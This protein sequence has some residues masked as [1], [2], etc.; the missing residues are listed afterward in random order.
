MDLLA[1]LRAK[2]FELRTEGERLIVSPASKLYEEDR[3]AIRLH[4]PALLLLLSGRGP[5]G[6]RL[7]FQPDPERERKRGKPVA[8]R[9]Y[10]WEGA[11]EWFLCD[12]PARGD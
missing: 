4:K 3:D 6:A 7:Y 8:P 9:R 5:G 10:T 12:P 2:G 11:P 1:R